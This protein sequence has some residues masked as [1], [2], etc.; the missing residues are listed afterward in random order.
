MFPCEIVDERVK[1]HAGIPRS[2]LTS[3]ILVQAAAAATSQPSITQRPMGLAWIGRV[4]RVVSA[5][6]RCGFTLLHEEQVAAHVSGERVVR[7][8]EV[9]ELLIIGQPLEHPQEGDD[10]LAGWESV[11]GSARVVEGP[12]C[13]G[14]FTA[15]EYLDKG[16]PPSDMMMRSQYSPSLASI[17]CASSLW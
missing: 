5:L 6:A 13:R 17:T 7:L 2:V 1:H 8:G 14:Q 12:Q 11:E 9:M 4:S 16:S 10:D 15:F 3:H